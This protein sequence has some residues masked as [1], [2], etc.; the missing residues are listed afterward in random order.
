MGLQVG[1]VFA[2]TITGTTAA[3]TEIAGP[4]ETSGLK[5]LVGLVADNDAVY[6]SDQTGN[7]IYKLAIPGNAQTKVADVTAPDLLFQMPNGDLLTG[8][9]PTITRI[10]TSDG[11]KTTL[12]NTGFELV[13]G[14]AVDPAQHRIFVIDHSTAAGTKDYLDIQPLAN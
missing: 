1:S 6:T 10:K 14:I 3:P 7:A 13:H 8:G 9:G 4:T 5:K 11:T 12:G 2:V